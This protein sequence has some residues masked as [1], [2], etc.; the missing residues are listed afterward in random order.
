MIPTRMSLMKSGLNTAF[1][2][3]IFLVQ[4]FLLPHSTAWAPASYVGKEAE[5]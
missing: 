1:C 3:P 2:Q 4:A 5:E